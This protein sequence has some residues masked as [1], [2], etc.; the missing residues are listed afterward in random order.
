MTKDEAEQ[1]EVDGQYLVGKEITLNIQNERNEPV[2][3]S[4]GIVT[5][6]ISSLGIGED[7]GP[8]NYSVNVLIEEKDSTKVHSVALREVMNA[9]PNDE[10]SEEAE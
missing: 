2:R 5:A 1:L 6:R 9:Y 3:T 8:I 4:Q 7:G 10:N